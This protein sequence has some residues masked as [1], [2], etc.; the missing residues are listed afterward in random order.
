M[1]MSAPLGHLVLAGSG[2][3]TPTMDIVDTHVLQHMGDG[4]VV[5]VATSCAQEG[6]DM[7][8]KWEQ[9]GV[10]HFKRLG[11]DAVPLRICDTDDANLQENADVIA[12]AGFVWFSGGSPV[13]LSMALE[14]TLAFRALEAANRRGVAQ[15]YVAGRRHGLARALARA[16]AAIGVVAVLV[17]FFGLRLER[18]GSGMPTMVTFCSTVMWPNGRGIW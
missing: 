12:N 4:P 17:Q 8:A 5:L 15:G 7:M 9:M 18:D 16:I 11:V 3:Y 6:Q 13:Y 14:D 10:A 1:T 2:E